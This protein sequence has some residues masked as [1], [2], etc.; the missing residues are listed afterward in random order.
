MLRGSFILVVCAAGVADVSAWL[1]AKPKPSANPPVL[2]KGLKVRGGGVYART[3]PSDEVEALAGEA[4]DWL[5]NL[6]APAALV[7]GA[8][9]Q[10]LSDEK[11]QLKTL[12]ADA[13]WVKIAKR[14]AH[15][16]LISSFALNILSI[17]ATTVTG[18]ML[19]SLG[20]RHVVEAAQETIS[21][22]GFLKNNYEFE[23]L[24][25]RVTFCQGLLHWLGGIALMYAVPH[26]GQGVATRKMHDF[27]AAALL[28][29]ILLIV[30]F[31]NGHTNF[32]DSYPHM[33]R[34]YAVSFF[35]R[36]FLS[37]ARPMALLF[38]PALAYNGYLLVAAVTAEADDEPSRKG[39]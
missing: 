22:M 26:E 9:L 12:R 18:T 14:T 15:L 20:D 29:M 28:N 31:W 23:Y 21:P 4:F 30:S 39:D 1:R 24:T 11:D 38:G 35:R 34:V 2:R 5:A 6:G 33:L 25:A 16:L 32:Y 3:I 10:T 19:K 36:Y 17:F 7:A 37:G 8:V 27:I 13:R